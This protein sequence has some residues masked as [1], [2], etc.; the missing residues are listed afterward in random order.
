MSWDIS[1]LQ[2]E[3]WRIAEKNGFHDD[4]RSRAKVLALVH[5]EVSEALEADR[6]PDVPKKHYAEELADI[7][8][9][10]LDHAEEESID[11][12]R[13]IM[14]KMSENAERDYKHGKNY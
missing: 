2:L 12:E 3:N 7:V 6:D 4:G 14:E 13:A 5:S 11:L 9:R 10:V 8:I 1:E